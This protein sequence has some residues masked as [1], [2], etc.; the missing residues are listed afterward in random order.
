MKRVILKNVKR[1]VGNVIINLFSMFIIRYLVFGLVFSC[2][3]GI[4]NMIK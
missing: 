3:R 1:L 2:S 4:I